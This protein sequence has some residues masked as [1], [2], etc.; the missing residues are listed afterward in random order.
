MYLTLSRCYSNFNL[1]IRKTGNRYPVL[2]RD[3]FRCRYK[4]NARCSNTESIKIKSFWYLF[5]KKKKET[6]NTII[7]RSKKTKWL[8]YV[9]IS[10]STFGYFINKLINDTITTN[11]ER[12]S[13][14]MPNLGRPALPMKSYI[15]TSWTPHFVHYGEKPI[16]YYIHI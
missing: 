8:I 10:M 5:W 9:T 12:S 15:A 6:R 1:K 14:D 13:F 3:N 4:L 16:F 7:L 2:N 11:K